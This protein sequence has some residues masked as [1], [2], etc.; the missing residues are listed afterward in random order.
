MRR[1]ELI[2]TV[3][4]YG[5]A[6]AAGIG[7]LQWLEVGMLARTHT[8]ELYGGMLAIGFLGLGIW[9]GARLFRRGPPAQTFEPNARAQETLG[10]SG[11]ELEV[12]ELLA[13]GKSNKEISAKLNVSPNT[14]KTHVAKL[15]GKLEAGRRTE[16]ILK[17]RELGIIR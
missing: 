1:W 17:A 8:F 4:V 9:V 16:A 12:L 3:L 13:S 15:Y 11:R 6:L 14:V 7:V 2:R 10:I 5:L